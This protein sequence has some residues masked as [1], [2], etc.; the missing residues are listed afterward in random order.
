MVL[1]FAFLFS[2]FMCLFCFAFKFSQVRAS[3]LSEK[4]AKKERMPYKKKKKN[5]GG[6]GCWIFTTHVVEHKCRTLQTLIKHDFHD[7]N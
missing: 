7:Q 1:Y 3:S 4:M 6:I 5:G 2:S